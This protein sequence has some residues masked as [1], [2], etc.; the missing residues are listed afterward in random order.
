MEPQEITLEE[1]YQI[2]G[3]LEVIRRKYIRLLTEKEK[4]KA[5]D[6]KK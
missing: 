5:D 2:I 1:L 3:E 6:E 4:P